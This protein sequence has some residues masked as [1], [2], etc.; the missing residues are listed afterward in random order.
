MGHTFNREVYKVGAYDDTFR[1]P[2]CDGTIILSEVNSVSAMR[3]ELIALW[4]AENE[5]SPDETFYNRQP[6]GQRI[7]LTARRIIFVHQRIQ[8]C[9]LVL[10]AMA[11]M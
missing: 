1:C 5:M 11:N 8:R 3:P 7:T 9:G 6:N 2:V 4:S 10:R